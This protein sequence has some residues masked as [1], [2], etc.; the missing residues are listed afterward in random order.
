MIGADSNTRDALEEE[1]HMIPIVTED[2]PEAPIEREAGSRLPRVEPF[3][4]ADLLLASSRIE[5]PRIAEALGFEE[6]R[7]FVEW[8]E[9]ISG[10][11]PEER[12]ARGQAK[13]STRSAG[14]AR[15]R[16]RKALLGAVDRAEAARLAGT[17]RA[18][19]R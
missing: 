1:R 17:L 10:E 14:A 15:R 11:S 13:L 12:R 3:D 18:G 6:A 9:R 4:V 8:F 16:W 2:D 19:L 7:Q 5:V